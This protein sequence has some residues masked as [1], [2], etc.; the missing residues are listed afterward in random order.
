MDWQVVVIYPELSLEP[1]DLRPYQNW[2]GLPEIYR[3]YLDQLAEEPSAPGIDLV[4]LIV[5]PESTAVDRAKQLLSQASQT[6]IADLSQKAIIELV[7]TIVVYKF[8]QLSRQEIEQ[9][10][11]LSALNKPESIKRR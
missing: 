1:A 7:E 5:E 10:L 3:I 11:N 8:P 9:M 4:R 6:A 2:L